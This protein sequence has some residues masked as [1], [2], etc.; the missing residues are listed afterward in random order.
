[1]HQRTAVV[2][3]GQGGY[4]PGALA[5]MAHLDE[6]AEV[7]D[8]VDKVAA[9]AGTASVSTLLTN[10]GAPMVN[11]LMLDDPERLHLAIYAGSIASWRLLSGPLG[12]VP[13]VLFGHSVGE[14]AA[15]TAGGAISVEDGARLL[16]AR[17]A[18]FRA[19]PPPLGGM[20]AI[21]LGS[22]RLIQ[23]VQGCGLTSTHIAADNAPRQS[24]VSG[25]D[26][27]LDVLVA[28]LDALEIE[29]FQLR[30]AYP[31]HSPLLATVA[32]R[33]R[34]AVQELEV[35]VPMLP[36]YSPTRGSYYR[37]AGSIKAALVDHLLLPVHFRQAVTTLYGEGISRFV[38]TG[39]KAI[40][41]DL[42]EQNLP[43]AETVAPLRTR[44][45]LG[46]MRAILDGTD[47]AF[48]PADSVSP[49][50]VPAAVAAEP[51]APAAAVSVGS[52]V[53][54]PELPVLIT[55]LQELYATDLEYP[56]DVMTADADLEADLAVDSVKQI[57]LFTRA[58]K[59]YGLSQ[60]A[61]RLR[62]TSY[63]TLRRIAALLLDLAAETG[64]AR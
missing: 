40:L 49:A 6:V 42:V 35:T 37:D 39:P 5:A 52:V 43:G 27:E 23:L 10:H 19:A 62:V 3:P 26:E 47:A 63:T 1:M 13:D 16:A 60:P 2:F 44:C 15:L 4:L 17:D 55:E 56:I 58:L 54:M 31:F 41:A 25:P 45:E 24:V 28:A 21:P 46:A 11:S 59:R 34:P 22:A 8:Q 12:L 7:L 29:H 61:G 53:A 9:E 14:L 48:V 57:E 50:A 32:T 38:D 51:V 18:A 33:F 36:V 30:S 20:L 64:T